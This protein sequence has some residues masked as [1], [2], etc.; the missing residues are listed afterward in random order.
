VSLD[1]N[2]AAL[3]WMERDGTVH[4]TEYTQHGLWVA[5][6]AS[7]FGLSLDYV[8]KVFDKHGDDD[9]D[10]AAAVMCEHAFKRGWLR[11]LKVPWNSK[12]LVEGP[13]PSRSQR[14]VLED[15]H[16]EHGWPVLWYRWVS[17]KFG[18]SRDT[19][20]FGESKASHIVN[21]LLENINYSHGHC[22]A[23]SAAIMNFSGGEPYILT[24]RN[25]EIVHSAVRMPHTGVFLDDMGKMNGEAE[26]EARKHEFDGGDRLMWQRTT[27]EKLRS[28]VSGTKS[29]A[30][31]R[32]S[33]RAR[34]LLRLD[35]P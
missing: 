35:R 10:G 32:A 30:V 13:E 17:S 2:N 4:D 31:R 15:W 1:Y 12:I 14:Q 22:H 8:R 9:I 5:D 23:L 6:N 26:L 25:G 16:F 18:P 34:Q 29:M 33:G 3:Y 27:P 24:D 7:L 11:C 20:L 19:I 28:L 21:V